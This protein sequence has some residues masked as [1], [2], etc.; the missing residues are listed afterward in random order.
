MGKNVVAMLIW[1]L[2]PNSTN[3]KNNAFGWLKGAFS[4]YGAEVEI[5]F[6]GIPDLPKSVLI[7]ENGDIMKLDGKHLPDVVLMRGYNSGLSM[8][9]EIRNIRVINNCK[10]MELSRDKWAT[11]TVLKSLSVPTPL[12]FFYGDEIPSFKSLTD[13]FLGKSFVMKNIFGSKGENVYLIED[14]DSF[15]DA[16]KSCDDTLRM[17]IFDYE[18]GNFGWTDG[19]LWRE[20]IEY[21]SKLIFQEYIE[22]S[23][24][25]D[26]RVW[27]IGDKVA[28]SLMR[29]NIGSFKSNYAQGGEAIECDLPNEGREIAISAAKA[30]GLEF[31][32]IDLLLADRCDEVSE[33]KN[34]TVC[35]VN[36]NAGFRTTSIVAGIDIPQRLSEYVCTKL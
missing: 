10:S 17:R 9:F 31:A 34:F 35:E 29:R 18:K 7:G 23:R 16:L 28:G 30:L 33:C 13:T 27:V 8:W 12:T 21:G 14:N 32:G 15:N 11:A 24:G 19:G 5:F 25:K 3:K 4:K 6:W 20:E 36:G 1:L 2:Y 26:V 22:E